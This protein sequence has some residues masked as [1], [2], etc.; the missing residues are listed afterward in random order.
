MTW[1]KDGGSS[2]VPAIILLRASVEQQRAQHRGRRDALGVEVRLRLA[3]EEPER[4]DHQE[5]GDDLDAPLENVRVA[6]QRWT[7]MV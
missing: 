7:L 1:R 3:D 6:P 2:F 4:S 5:Q